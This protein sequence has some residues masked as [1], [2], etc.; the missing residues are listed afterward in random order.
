[1]APGGES[2]WSLVLK[3]F[4]F[5]VLVGLLVY[6]VGKPL[7]AYLSKRHDTVKT[8]LE[9]TEKVLKD[10]QAIRAQYQERL[11]K[12]DGEIEVFK[13]QTMQE[14]EAEKKKIIE[15]AHAFAERIREQA[16]LTAEQENKD[17]ARRIKEE[18][19]R[20]TMEKAEQLITEKITQSDHDKLV[21]EF[22][23]KLRSMN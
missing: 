22:I 8:R 16:R 9:E 2:A 13:K 19:S 12:L 5:F 15:E 6:F 14:A 3:F 21:E 17:M 20:L 18:I 4:N 7:K 10:A 1:M 23:V 11:D